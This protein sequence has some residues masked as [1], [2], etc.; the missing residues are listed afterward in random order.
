[1]I[2]RAIS[3]LGTCAG[4]GGVRGEIT[5]FAR[6]R[7]FAEFGCMTYNLARLTLIGLGMYDA[8]QEYI[9]FIL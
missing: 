2:A 8:D 4:F 7:V 9:Y 3:G 6:G 5:Y 1:V